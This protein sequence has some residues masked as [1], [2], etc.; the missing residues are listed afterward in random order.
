V[1]VS[2]DDFTARLLDLNTRIDLA[3]DQ[4]SRHLFHARCADRRRL[5]AHWHKQCESADPRMAKVVQ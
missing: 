2:R 4:R 3:L 5:L 1:Y